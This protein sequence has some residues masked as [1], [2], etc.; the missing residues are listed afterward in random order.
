MHYWL[1]KEEAIARL[2]AGSHVITTSVGPIEYTVKG[3]GPTVLVVHA[4]G[5][6]YDQGVL[7]TKLLNRD[8]YRFIIP[9][10]FGYL[11]TP[12]PNTPTPQAQADAFAELLDALGIEQVVIVAV[13]AGG[14]SALQFCL[15]YPHRCRGLVLMSALTRPVPAPPAAFQTITNLLLQSDFAVWLL[16]H[17]V[18]E[19]ILSLYGIKDSRLAYAKQDA[20]KMELLYGILKTTF[21]I[22]HRHEGMNNDIAQASSITLFPIQQI[23]T[24]ILA[25]HGKA[26]PVVGFDHG[27][28]VANTAPNATLI[29]IEG[30]DHF[31]FIT[32][33]ER[34]EQPVQDFLAAHAQ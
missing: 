11:R 33:K 26:D 13:S 32:S 10:R 28:F 27:V 7:F 9:S 29:P 18:P 19:Q 31:C 34:I 23:T 14:M 24:P 1:D 6:G 5:G 4:G 3:E 15:R 30:G 2:A 22:S 16:T 20:E 25:I 17:S 21:P 12:L 8:P